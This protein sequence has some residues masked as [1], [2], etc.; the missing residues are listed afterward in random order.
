ML[1]RPSELAAC[2]ARTAGTRV[3]GYRKNQALQLKMGDEL[4]RTCQK[5]RN[6]GLVTLAGWED[7]VPRVHWTRVPG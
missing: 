7:R 3:P 1:L 4:N 6:L 5:D 2:E